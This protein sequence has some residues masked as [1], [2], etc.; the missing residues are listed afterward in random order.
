MQ[1]ALEADD[2]GAGVG[3]EGFTGGAFGPASDQPT[4][5]GDGELRIEVGCAPGA[6]RRQQGLRHDAPGAE[7]PGPLQEQE[8]GRQRA[9]A[10][11]PEEGTRAFDQ[12]LHAPEPVGTPGVR[13]PRKAFRRR[14]RSSSSANQVTLADQ[15]RRTCPG[16]VAGRGRP[17]E[18]PA[19]PPPWTC[20]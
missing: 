7:N 2:F 19:A 6:D 8:E 3:L 14:G 20:H 13:K 16:C 11:R 5:R 12:G 15:A 17:R 18:R 1:A 9:E 4:R 10:Q